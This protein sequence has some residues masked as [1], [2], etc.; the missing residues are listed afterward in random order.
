MAALAL[1]ALAIVGASARPNHPTPATS[2]EPD[3]Y[4]A[5]AN[6]S[7]Y[8]AQATASTSQVPKH[9]VKGKAFD[10]FIT[11]WM[12]NT[13][14]DKAAADPNLAWLATKGI[15]LENYYGVTHP[16]E[17]NYVAS[18]GGGALYL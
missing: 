14:Y 6:T 9:Y 13:D 1:G 7:V 12:E 4:T 8:A 10:R 17:P 15:T 5:T 11:I 18:V 16:S 2:L 3:L